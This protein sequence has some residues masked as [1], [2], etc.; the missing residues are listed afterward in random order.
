MFNVFVLM[1][2]AFGE[3]TEAVENTV[4]EKA[5]AV[6]TIQELPAPYKEQIILAKQQIQ[7]NNLDGAEGSLDKA[8]KEIAKV[9]TIVTSSDISEIWYLR[10][11][12]QSLRGE[13]PLESWRQTLIIN[14]GQK[15]DSD[16]I[17]DDASQDLFLALKTEVQNRKIVSVQH[18][19][20]YGQAKLYVDGFLRA[21]G[22]FVYQGEH[23]AQIEC[24]KG[25]VHS[26]WTDFE[27]TFKWIK[28]CP[29]KF[30]VTDM[31]E[32]EAVDEWDMFGGFGG[33]ET[34]PDVNLNN[35]VVAGPLLERMDKPTLYGSIG[36][37]AAA[38]MLYAVALKNN[39]KFDD[40]DNGLSVEELDSLRNT[41]N[42]IAISSMT[43][44]IV[45][46]GLYMYSMS[47]A[48]VSE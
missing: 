2:V 14:L 34:A 37:A 44:G 25:D 26:K 3:E 48:K 46:G 7:S 9:E 27:K 18:P 39:Q 42:T 29:Y 19:E 16:L 24:P 6:D 43:F 13:D 20:Q 47:T 12:V 15:W 28:M 22:D 31:P 33:E 23:F 5:E 11:V 35:Q 45:S 30:D 17:K 8:Q 4:A 32:P 40:L 1:S 10:G 41:T 36:T 21:P 38:G